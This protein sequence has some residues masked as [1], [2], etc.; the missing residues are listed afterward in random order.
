MPFKIV[1]KGQKPEQ[2][3]LPASKPPSPSQP[4]KP[5]RVD[6]N[7]SVQTLWGPVGVKIHK[8]GSRE[9]LFN[10]VP[11]NEASPWLKEYHEAQLRKKG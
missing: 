2:A 6:R 4:T 7:K 3:T 9:T 8:D 11:E 5:P 10:S 1:K